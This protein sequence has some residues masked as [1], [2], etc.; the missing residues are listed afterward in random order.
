MFKG[1]VYFDKEKMTLNW[2]KSKVVE[3]KKGEGKKRK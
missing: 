2:E 3:F 1:E